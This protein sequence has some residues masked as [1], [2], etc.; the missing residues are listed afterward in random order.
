M[1]ITRF[2]AD[3]QTHI[4]TFCGLLQLFR[5]MDVHI[6]QQLAQCT[7]WELMQILI[8][9]IHEIEYRMTARPE[10]GAAGGDIEVEY[11][12]SESDDAEL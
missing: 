6:Q 12:D 3:L 11:S 7:L 5:A 1:H 4:L 2:F 9:L 8:Y 10:G